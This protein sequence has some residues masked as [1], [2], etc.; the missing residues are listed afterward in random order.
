ME[1]N[2]V[3]YPHDSITDMREKY[4]PIRSGHHDVQ[5]ADGLRYLTSPTVRCEHPPRRE[6]EGRALW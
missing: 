2:P 5:I 1:S 4:R 3:G 6:F